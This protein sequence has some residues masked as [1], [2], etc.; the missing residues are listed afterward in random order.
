MNQVLSITA[1]ENTGFCDEPVDFLACGFC[2]LFVGRFLPRKFDAEDGFV[3]VDG[4]L[5]FHLAWKPVNDAFPV[6]AFEN[7][8]IRNEALSL[9]FLFFVGLILFAHLFLLCRVFFVFPSVTEGPFTQLKARSEGDERN[10]AA[11]P[12]PVSAAASKVTGKAWHAARSGGSGLAAECSVHKNTVKRGS[13]W[14]SFKVP[15][16]S[17]N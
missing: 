7:L 9:V 8:R 13:S 6:L 14:A 12:R 11:K 17:E 2:L 16:K 10:A 4:H 15:T 3:E 5:N 1:E